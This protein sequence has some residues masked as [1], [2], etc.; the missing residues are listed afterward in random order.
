MKIFKSAFVLFLMFVSSHLTG[1][2]I[3][4]IETKDFALVLET[5]SQQRL[6]N[7]YFGKRLSDKATYQQIS[8]QYFF[9]DN[10]AGLYNHAYTPA[11]TW[12]LSEPALQ[13]RHV[14]GNLS[15]ELKFISSQVSQENGATIT[16]VKMQDPVYNLI[17]NLYYKVWPE[18]NVLEQLSEIVNSEKGDI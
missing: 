2:T 6:W 5:D 11:G 3:I 7:V 1:Q 14:D 16:V 9:P 18:L 8:K 12:N 4:P 13:V 17:V 10:N 15:T